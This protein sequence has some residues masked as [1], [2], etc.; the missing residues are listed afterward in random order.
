MFNIAEFARLS[1]D[2]QRAYHNSLKYYRDLN[3]AVNT[4]REEG[5]EEGRELGI[6]EGRELGIE[7][8]RELGIEEGR[9]L[10]IEEGMRSLLIRQISRK[11]SSIP[12]AITD[13]LSQLSLEQ[14]DTLAE[15][16]FNIKNVEDLIHWL[17]EREK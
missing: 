4:S 5:W 12:T 17:D 3:N 10:G 1:A 14:L 6:E 9:E 8:G 16:I 15:Y 13:R 2:E 7:E 11:I